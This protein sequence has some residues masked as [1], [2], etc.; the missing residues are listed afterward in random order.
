MKG[1]S[2]GVRV[3]ST[4][5]FNGVTESRSSLISGGLARHWGIGGISYFISMQWCILGWCS[6]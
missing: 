2:E 4:L 5:L 3:F 1:C 6:R